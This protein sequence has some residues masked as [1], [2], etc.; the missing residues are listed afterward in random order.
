MLETDEDLDCIEWA[1]AKSEE[2]SLPAAVLL[3][4]HAK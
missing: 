4:G 3:I 2:T 1:Y